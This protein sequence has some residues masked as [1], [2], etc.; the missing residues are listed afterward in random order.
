MNQTVPTDTQLIRQF[1]AGEISALEDLV[2]RYED[3][4]YNLAYR[5][6]RNREDAEDV[7]QD[8]FLSVIRA[9]DKFKGK[10]SFS[11][12]I[13]R[14][15]TNAALTKLRQRSRKLKTEGEFLDE[16]YSVHKQAHAGA[17]MIDW[18]A[19]PIESVLNEEARQVMEEAI[20]ELP[21]NYRVVF[22]LR[23]VEGLPAS[24]VAEVLDLSVPAVKSRLHRARLFLRNRLS[25]YYE[26]GA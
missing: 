3:Q 16:I 19:N 9:L 23:D 11:T 26:E 15:A 8:T 2:Y 1:R 21:E 10:S 5:M 13:Y 24:D 4:V 18:A 17:T 14:I 6:L 22:V 25:R 12:W 20:A 7:L